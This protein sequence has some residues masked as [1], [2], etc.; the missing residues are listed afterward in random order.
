MRS[1]AKLKGFTKKLQAEFLQFQLDQRR[2]SR[3]GSIAQWLLTDYHEVENLLPSASHIVGLPGG[4]KLPLQ[5]TGPYF[6]SLASCVV[7][8]EK[9][10][11]MVALG[12]GFT[13]C[14]TLFSKT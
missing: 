7:T 8:P 1:S 14:T 2:Q 6:S 3:W 11:V 13:G 9:F 12:V 5:I 4:A 10:F